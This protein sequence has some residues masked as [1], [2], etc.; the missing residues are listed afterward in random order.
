MK[1]TKKH[2]NK[3]DYRTN[4][5]TKSIEYSLPRTEDTFFTA[6]YRNLFIK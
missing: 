5:I 6:Y 3:L 1:S 4:G 2:Q